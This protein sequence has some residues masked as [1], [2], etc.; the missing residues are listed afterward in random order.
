MMNSRQSIC[1]PSRAFLPAGLFLVVVALLGVGLGTTPGY[2][3]G[4]RLL[5]AGHASGT[6]L[7]G[8]RGPPEALEPLIDDLRKGAYRTGAT[9][10]EKTLLA[11]HL[12]TQLTLMRQRPYAELED[13]FLETGDL[14]PNNF[15]VEALWGQTLHEAGNFEKAVTHLETAI[16]ID[17]DDLNV[18]AL[19]GMALQRMMQYERALEHYERILKE[20]PKNF[21]LLFNM[22]KCS[23][24]IKEYDKA[25]EYWERALACAP[26][27]NARAGVQQHIQKAKEQEAST[28]GSTTDENQRFIIHYAG[29]SQDDIGDITMETLE[30]IYDQVTSDLQY[31][32]DIKIVVIFFRTEEFYKVNNAANW[33]G[34]IARGAKILVPLKQGYANMQSVR[35]ILAHEFTHVIVNLRT[36]NR[37]PTW[38]NEGLAVYHEFIGAYGDPTTMRPDYEKLMQREI[39]GNQRFV[40]PRSINLNPSTPTYGIDIPLGYLTS[41][42]AV[43]FMIERWGW[44]GIDQLLTKIGEGSYLDEALVEGTGMEYPNFE[45]E[46]FDWLKT[47]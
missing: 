26:D 15:W 29:N 8:Y 38:I 35:G 7:L 23:F 4:H 44:S 10:D 28:A 22:G 6:F 27:D 9:Q 11:A 19:A 33:V 1:F 40:S 30:E 3:L 24:E 18:R 37:C 41:Y 46:F 45:R 39:I 13:Q 16:Q 2:A 21:S 17:A 34:A 47:F 5:P 36:N 31:S 14:V 43:R 20:E 32:P 12:L 25:I 42:L